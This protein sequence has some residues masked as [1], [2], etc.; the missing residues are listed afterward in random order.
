MVSFVRRC[1]KRLAKLFVDHAFGNQPIQHFERA[2][3]YNFLHDYYANDGRYRTKIARILEAYYA[4]LA[5]LTKGKLR[6]IVELCGQMICSL[7]DTG[8]LRGL[9]LPLLD[10]NSAFLRELAECLL[11]EPVITRSIFPGSLV[12]VVVDAAYV[13]FCLMT[14]VDIDLEVLR[15]LSSS[16]AIFAGLAFS[17]FSKF[18]RQYKATGRVSWSAWPKALGA[19]AVLALIVIIVNA[20][21]LAVLLIARLLDEGISDDGSFW[22]VA[23]ALK[24]LL[25][26]GDALH[27][28]L[29]I[30]RMLHAIGRHA[31]GGW[32]YLVDLVALAFIVFE[33]VK[34]IAKIALL[35]PLYPLLAYTLLTYSFLLARR[36]WPKIRRALRKL[37]NW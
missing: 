30:L 11:R 33:A 34:L 20:P 8:T 28:M 12:A 29:L 15:R 1:A 24:S 7:Y 4:R 16:T 5:K 23:I 18:Y 17:Y 35:W 37:K 32:V 36:V 13:A 9:L 27:S 31:L 25:D 26:G 14:G 19:L 21:H 6:E 2:W 22:V 3:L 10:S